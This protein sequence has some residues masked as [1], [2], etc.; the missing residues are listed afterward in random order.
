MSIKRFSF[1]FDA[2]VWLMLGVIVIIAALVAL[3][4]YGTHLELQQWEEFKVAHSC[5]I[6]QKMKIPLT[7]NPVVTVGGGGNVGTGITASGGEEKKG[8][9]CD[10]GIVYW[11]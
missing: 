4:L 1:D 10:D 11:R 9:L 8:W 5:E 3:C 2:E 7:L 6:T